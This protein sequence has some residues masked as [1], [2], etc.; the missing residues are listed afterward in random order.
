MQW[1]SAILIPVIGAFIGW[2]TN[3]IAVKAI[4]KPYQPVRIF[5]LPWA[6]QGVVPKRRTELARSIGEVV[7]K[8]LL[9]VED[10]M[11]QM[12]SPEVLN[13]IVLS[14]N[15]S[16]RCMVVERIPAWV[17]ATIKTVI[18]EMMGDM[19]NKQMPQ[20]INQI[21]DQA[22]RSVIEKVKLA[23]LVED[24]MNAYDIK[25]LEKIILSVAARELKHIEIIGGVL[26][27]VIGLVQVAIIYL[28]T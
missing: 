5:G 21:V 12:K 22:G 2:V 15:D 24:R 1:W 20:V 7:E 14:A 16:I 27:F 19:L 10:L 13:K 25:H 6:I 23:Q 18:L 4:F 9:K 26:G 17:P 8:E 28:S 11:N 3:L